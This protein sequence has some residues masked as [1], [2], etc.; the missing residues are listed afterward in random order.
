MAS[1]RRISW[2][3]GGYGAQER[4]G[5]TE[6]PASV[7]G[8]GYELKEFPQLY[9]WRPAVLAVHGG[10]MDDDVIPALYRRDGATAKVGPS[11][12]GGT[13]MHGQACGLPLPR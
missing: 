4:R 11:G 8:G 6:F 12:G 5:V 9:V 1:E 10:Q 7:G 2:W 3:P 13:C